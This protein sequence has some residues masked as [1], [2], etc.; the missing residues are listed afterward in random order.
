[1]LIIWIVYS[2][3]CISELRKFK[4]T[5]ERDSNGELKLVFSRREDFE[6]EEEPNFN[7]RRY[8]VSHTDSISGMVDQPE[9]DDAI[10]VRHQE[11]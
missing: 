11:V 8:Q 6:N 7:A 9:E 2:Q 4:C 3:G 10:S 1:M 5:M